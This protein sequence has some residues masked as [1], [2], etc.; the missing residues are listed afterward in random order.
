MMRIAAGFLCDMQRE[1]PI[2]RQRAEKFLEQLRVHAADLVAGEGHLP[3]QE[4][5][6]GEV[7]GGFGQRLVHR[8]EGVAEPPDAALVAERA[9]QG[10]AEH[11]A[12]ILGGMVAVDMQIAFR[13]HGQVEQPV[14]RQCGQHVVEEADAGV[15][16]AASRS[17][18]VEVEGDIGFRRG[19]GEADGA[20]AHDVQH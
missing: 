8:H 6:A 10:L 4:G 16:V 17:I 13:P 2:K 3:G 5:A 12:D 15:D 7:D 19:A 18:E 1:Q 9:V 11:D 20:R 14:P